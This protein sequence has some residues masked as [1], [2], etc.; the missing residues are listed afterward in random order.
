MSGL[1]LHK[2]YSGTVE[3]DLE[4]G[5]LRGEA[6]FITDALTYRG[7]TIK[8]LT[9]AFRSTVDG[10]ME[11]CAERGI[12]PKKPLSGTVTIRIGEE[13]H[14]AAALEAANTGKTI[15]QLVTKALASSLNV[16]FEQRSRGRQKRAVTPENKAGARRPS[17]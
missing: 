8:E 14:R 15:N 4:E 7:R 13:L 2:G 11:L 10:Y 3:P 5:D 6:L 12:E 16:H 1:L 17:V 9:T